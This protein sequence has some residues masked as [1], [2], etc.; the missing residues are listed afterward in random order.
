MK[1][2]Y[3]NGNIG[4]DAFNS[5]VLTIGNF[6]GCHIGHQAIFRRTQEHAR[7]IG[8]DAVAI[9]FDPHPASVIKGVTPQLIY[10][11]EEKIEAIRDVGMDGLVVAPFT[12][13]LA[14]MDPESFVREIIVD[15]VGA[16][17]VV[18]GYDFCFGRKAAGNFTFL[19]RMG[20]KYGFFVERVDPVVSDGIVVSS[21][22]IRQLIQR[23][24]MARVSQLLSHPYRIRGEVVHGMSRG[25]SLGFPTAN[26]RADKAFIPA[27]GVYAAY[28]RLGDECLR[29]VVNIGNN[30]T[31]E[32][33]GTSIE[34]Y[35]F[36]FDRII[37]GNEIVVEFVDYLRGEVR[38]PDKDYLVEQMERDC[39]QAQEIF[40]RLERP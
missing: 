11:I 17:G 28:V 20:E 38:F 23:G 3:G 5:P 39:A 4:R 22:C 12:R 7:K 9:T 24:D 34:V 26:I 19:T 29:G 32:G 6:D 31:F 16:R 30:P 25:K 8:G 27:Y 14:D 36:D 40:H 10:T 18:I 35:L 21:T 37:Y 33:V 1:T 15:L 13:E 2:F